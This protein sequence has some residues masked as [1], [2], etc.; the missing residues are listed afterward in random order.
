MHFYSNIHIMNNY[1]YIDFLT[2]NRIIWK[3]IETILMP[4]KQRVGGSNPSSPTRVLE[5]SKQIRIQKRYSYNITIPDC[6]VFLFVAKPFTL[7]S[8][9]RGK[10]IIKI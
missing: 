3:R 9:N 7:T 6:I 10:F 4:Y 1:Y 2:H 5:R 8:F